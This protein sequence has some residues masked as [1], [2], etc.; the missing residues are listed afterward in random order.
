MRIGII[1]IGNELLS[2]KRQDKHL[3]QMI[4]LF[5]A[6]GLQLSWV[7]VVGDDAAL[8]TETLN[9]VFVSGDLAFSFGGIG[10]TPDDL[11]RACAARA[12]GAEL[13]R[14]PEAVAII[15]DKFADDAYPNRIHMAELPANARLIP[16]PINQMPGFS[17]GDMHFVPGFPTM[18]WP[19]CEWVLDNHYAHLFSSDRPIEALYKLHNAH[20]SELIPMMESLL[21]K[22]PEVQLSS[23]PST[24]KRHEI[25]I[26]L[27]GLEPQVTAAG[28]WMLQALAAAKVEVEALGLR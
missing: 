23:L 6:R 12:I 7:R 17:V 3:A 4:E 25:E 19:M 28:E 15:E 27:T 24:E 5:R 21:E 1:L 11:T 9:Q 13:I 22:F 2:G 16:N 10:A 26:G 14:H 18:A 20:E 8:L